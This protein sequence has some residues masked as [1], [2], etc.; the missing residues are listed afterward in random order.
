MIN[1]EICRSPNKPGT[2]N[3]RTGD[4]DGSTDVY[5]MSKDDIIDFI[6]MEMNNEP[7]K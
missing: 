4:I 6:L 7:D 2:W 1:I 5:N 3:M